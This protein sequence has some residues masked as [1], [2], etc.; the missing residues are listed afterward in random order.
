MYQVIKCVAVGDG[1]SGKTSLLRNFASSTGA[2]SNDYIPTV[3]D[4]YS[5]NL[6]V[7]DD[8]HEHCATVFL[9]LFDTPGQEEFDKLRTLCY[10]DADVILL[11]FSVVN[12]SSL[13]HGMSQWYDEIKAYRCVRLHALNNYLIHRH[14][15][16]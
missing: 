1:C 3:L 12:P 5:R 10:L 13:N 16:L 4:N 14:Q 9:D 2:F 7:N 8:K 6:H 15:F 11:V